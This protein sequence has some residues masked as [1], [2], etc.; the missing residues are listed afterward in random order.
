MANRVTPRITANAVFCDDIRQELSGKFI[1]IGVYGDELH[2]NAGP[3][4]IPLSVWLQVYGI[5]AGTHSAKVIARK[6][7][8]KQSIEVAAVDVEIS[9]MKANHGLAISLPALP[10]H[11]DSDCTFSVSVGIDGSELVRAGEIAIKAVFADA[12]AS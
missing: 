8:G 11:V 2:M 6:H 5:G 9:V 4:V 3:G 12:P 10:I 7:V 1:L